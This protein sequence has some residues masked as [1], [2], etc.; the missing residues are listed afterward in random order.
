MVQQIGFKFQLEKDRF[1]T[2]TTMILKIHL[3][4]KTTDNTD[5]IIPKTAQ[6]D[7]KV[8]KIK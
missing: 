8:S 3:A 5:K 7:T 2:A 6:K 4:I 1:A